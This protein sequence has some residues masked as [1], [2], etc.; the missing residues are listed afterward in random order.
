MF[1]RQSPIR[2]RK[3]RMGASAKRFSQASDLA[4][5]GRA[6]VTLSI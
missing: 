5:D 3:G 1:M 2:T 4:Q 6:G